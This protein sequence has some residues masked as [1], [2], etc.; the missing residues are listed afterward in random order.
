[1]RDPVSESDVRGVDLAE[2]GIRGLDLPVMIREKAGTLARVLGRVEAAVALPHY[3][4]GTHMS[5]FVEILNRWSKKAIAGSEMATMLGELRETFHS[6]RALLRLEFKY[7]L[8]KQAPVSGLISQLDYDCSFQGDVS[9]EGYVF[10]LGA[11]VPIMTVCPCSKEISDRG[12]HNQRAI[13]RVRLHTLPDTVLWLEDL[14]PLLESQGSYGI[15]PVLKRPDEKAVTEAA[16]DNPKF[17]EDV[18]RDTILALRAT[19]GITWYSVRCDSHESIHNHMAYA[20]GEGG[21]G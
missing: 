10:T 16:Y 8:A 6:P 2:V 4:R 1:M 7:F 20:Y 21:T 17:V 18:V 3:E 19:P 15:F 11:D 5:R 9:D 12:A 14:I 13:L